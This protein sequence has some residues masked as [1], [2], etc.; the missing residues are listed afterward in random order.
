M[1]YLL[2][3]S[4]IFYLFFVSVCCLNLLFLNYLTSGSALNIPAASLRDAAD[5]FFA[6]AGR[7]FLLGYGII[8]DFL[9]CV[10]SYFLHI[11]RCALNHM[12]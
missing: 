7:I 5:M 6:V 4:I 2:L 3:F 1:V 12:S 11:D 10:N 9:K 8:D